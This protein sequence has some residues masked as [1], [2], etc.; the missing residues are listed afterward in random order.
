MYNGI[1]LTTAR[2]SGTNGYVQTNKFF[3][4]PKTNRVT[5]ST[6][7]FEDG[8]GTAGLS[9]RKPNK[10]ILEHDRKRQIEVQLVI[11]EDKLTEQGFTDSEIADK[12]AETRKVLEAQQEKDEEEGEVV[13]TPTH[14]KKFSDTQ[15][16][17]IAARK[18]K[19]ME[20]FRAALGIGLSESAADPPVMSNQKNGDK[21]EHSFL[22]RDRPPRAVDVDELKKA[23]KKKGK[24]VRDEIEESKHRKKKKVH[25]RSRH[26]DTDSYTDSSIE[27]SRKTTHRRKSRKA[28]DSE[29][30]LGDDVGGRTK[31][32]STKKQGRRRPDDIDE[33]GFGTGKRERGIHKYKSSRHESS[34][35]DSDSDD[36]RE[37]KRRNGKTDVQKYRSSHRKHDSS[38]DDFDSDDARKKNRSEVQKPK[39][40]LSGSHK[41]GRDKMGS[42]SGSDLDRTRDRKKEMVKRGRHRYDSEDESDSDISAD[43]KV[44]KSRRRG[45]RHNSDISS[46]EKVE[47]SSG[48]GRRH[49]SDIS[50]DEKEEKSRGRGRRH[51]SSDDEDSD[52]A[53][54]RKTSK[55]TTPKQRDEG[56]DS[57][58]NS[59][60][61]DSDSSDQKQIVG[62]NAVDKDR[63]GDKGDADNHRGRDS[64]QSSQEDKGFA[65]GTI[66]NDERRERTLYEDERSERLGKSENHREL[67][68][69]KR[70]LDEEY[71]DEQRESKSRSRNYGKDVE[72]TRDDP[73]GSKLDF[74]STAR[75]Y[76]EKD[77]RKRDAYSREVR[78]GGEL[79]R[80]NGRQDDRIQ[81]K[82]SESHRGTRRNDWDYE[83]QRGGRRQSRD[84][85]ESQDRKHARDEM[86]HKYR[87]HERDVERQRENHR[88]RK[89]EEDELGNKGHSRDRQSER[90]ERAP[91]DDARSS[92][93]RSRRDD[94]R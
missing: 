61:K 87:S 44:E 19:Q 43:E 75:A 67:M 36:E 17:Q 21:R 74:E 90:S 77:D 92:E 9:T 42:E 89:G 84:E 48:R 81:G 45:R 14:Q 53:Y 54:G 71:S 57:D 25:K 11:L 37:K 59:S 32:N 70:K 13:P 60:D 82:S 76:R 10:D 28:C 85:Q 27:H 91:Y 56:D 22:D 31:K 93:R 49:D 79:D 26:S 1:G 66:K 69:G 6:R 29:S 46:D 7:P 50:S 34:E 12:L 64:H 88:E 40:E 94:R 20:T 86:G 5:D 33:S 51:D 8:Q 39:I 2:G 41:R 23:A 18:E 35:D 72:R 4:R 30:D 80:Y 38:E 68:K 73:K 52:S 47:K 3:V 65:S 16:H 15:T 58:T 62:K 55:P 83:E 24:A 63:G 78:Y